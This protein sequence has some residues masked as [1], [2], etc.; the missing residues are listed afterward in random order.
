MMSKRMTM[1]LWK[2]RIE[3]GEVRR[4]WEDLLLY[5]EAFCSLDYEWGFPPR[6]LMDNVGILS[7]D[8]AWM[9]LAGTA[10]FSKLS[11]SKSGG[12]FNG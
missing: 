12:A 4:R 8:S 6:P 11:Y 1:T 10:A 7:P 5:L 3:G 9:R 2:I